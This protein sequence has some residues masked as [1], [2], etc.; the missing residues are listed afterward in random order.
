[1]YRVGYLLTQSV[2]SDNLLNNG[3]MLKVLAKPEKCFKWREETL[4][5]SQRE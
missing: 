4:K 3:Y 1:M 2:E 5:G